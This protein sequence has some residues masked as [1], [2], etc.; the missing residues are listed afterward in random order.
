MVTSLQAELEMWVVFPSPIRFQPVIFHLCFGPLS[1]SWAC[2]SESPVIPVATLGFHTNGCETA[3]SLLSGVLVLD[4]LRWVLWVARNRFTSILQIEGLD[5][6]KYWQKICCCLVTKSY[7]SSFATPWTIA[8]QTPLS[9]GFPRPKYW[10]GLPFPCPWDLLDPGIE[11]E[12]PV[13]TGGFFTTE[14]PVKPQV[15]KRH[16]SKQ[17]NMRTCLQESH[18]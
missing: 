5:W 6:I 16:T 7:P 3:A 18:S 2:E 15:L 9:M 8:H 1:W 14:P 10:T 17:L 4:G 11:P 12:S 13:L